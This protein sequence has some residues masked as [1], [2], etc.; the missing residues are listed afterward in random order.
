MKRY[1]I[2]EVCSTLCFPKYWCARDEGEDS[3]WAIASKISPYGG[4]SK[5]QTMA[6][7]QN[8]LRYLILWQHGIIKITRFLEGYCYWSTGSTYRG[9]QHITAEGDL[10]LHWSGQYYVKLSDHPELK[11]HNYCRNPGG[12]MSQPWCYTG[13]HWKRAVCDIPQCGKYK[14]NGVSTIL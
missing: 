10:C 1:L 14:T 13:Q 11:G 12:V 4:F 8:P 7:S 9:T 2:F 3:D 6:R 5:C